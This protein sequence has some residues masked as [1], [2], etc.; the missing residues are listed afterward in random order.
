MSFI[1]ETTHS[2]CQQTT[3]FLDI[4][5]VCSAST[6]TENKALSTSKRCFFEPETVQN[7]C[8]LWIF[9]KIKTFKR[10]LNSELQV[11]L[12][13]LAFLLFKNT[14]RLHTINKS[15]E[16]KISFPQILQFV[17]LFQTFI[18]AKLELDKVCVIDWF[19]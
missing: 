1:C 16:S 8:M 15:R 19:I 6:Q 14:F 18:P 7:N 11:H 17:F 5:E 2:F 4:N 13:H 9:Y 3:L 12:V 10:I